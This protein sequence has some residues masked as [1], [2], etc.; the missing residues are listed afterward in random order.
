[1]GILFSGGKQSFA[2][3]GVCIIQE[4]FI[5]AY[6]NEDETAMMNIFLLFAGSY[7]H[8][9]NESWSKVI[10]YFCFVFFGIVRIRS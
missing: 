8:I 1:M 9:H 7:V 4:H 5:E 6:Q 10:A 2:A 3:K